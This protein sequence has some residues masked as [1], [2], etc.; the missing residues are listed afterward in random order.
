MVQKIN[1]LIHT[2]YQAELLKT[3]AEYAALQAQ[4]NPHFLYN[5]LD[6]I[7]WQ[8]KLAQNEEIFETTYSLASLLRAS[9]S[10]PNPYVTVKEEPVSYT[11]LDVYKRQINNI[12]RH[13]TSYKDIPKIV[14]GR[15]CWPKRS[16]SF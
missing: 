2:V 16:N 6:T 14:Q 3:E 5:T 4:M 10:N 1:S 15:F 13:I 12:S 11:H 9:M 8:A 7:C